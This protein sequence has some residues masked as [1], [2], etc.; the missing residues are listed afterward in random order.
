MERVNWTIQSFDQTCQISFDLAISSFNLFL[1]R[2]RFN[3]ENK[4]LKFLEFKTVNVSQ[5][6][7]VSRLFYH[8]PCKTEEKQNMLKH[9][10]TNM[11]KQFNFREII[12][13]IID[14]MN[15]CLPFVVKMCH[16]INKQRRSVTDIKGFFGR[17][18][19]LCIRCTVLNCTI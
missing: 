9:I 1:L 12:T 16:K 11:L 10:E 3:N 17:R 19:I 8:T 14:I 18:V 13:K 15:P 2:K 6:G 4:V 5:H 7:R